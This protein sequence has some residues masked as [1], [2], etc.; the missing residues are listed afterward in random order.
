MS[1]VEYL[2]R[3][4]FLSG[5]V[6]FGVALLIF[7]VSQVVPS[8]P[9]SLYAGPR[10]SADQIEAARASLRLDDPVL[11]RFTTF[12]TNMASG[13]FGVSYRTRRSIAQ[14]L[15]VFLPATLEL[16]F[17][18][19]LFALI[20]GVPLGV[21]AAARRGRVVD[22]ILSFSS[23]AHLVMPALTLAAYPAGVAMRLTRSS[24][25][26]I[27]ARRHITAARALGI[28]ERRILFGHAL[29][30]AMAPALT[31]VGLS[32]AFA[33]TGAV[34]VE[35]IFAWPGLGKYIFEAVLSKDF[36][37]IA[38]TAFVVSLCYVLMNLVID[39]I[40]ALIDPRITV[41]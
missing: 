37:V 17:L 25:I 12:L 4:L 16:A 35:I 6:V 2:L 38:A 22:R 31:I 26:D 3:R 40:Q 23:V 36:P 28:S 33:L 20:I 24:M 39:L 13:D 5:F 1:F 32:F 29:P 14:D 9:A 21:W 18:S 10:P 15:Q 30:N 27:L 7:V 11:V 8:D 19:T 41:S 34:L